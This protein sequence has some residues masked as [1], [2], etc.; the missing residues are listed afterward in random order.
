VIGT[1]WADVNWSDLTEW[2]LTEVSDDPAYAEVVTPLLLEILR[3][4]PDRAY[5]DVGCG[6]GRVM[7]AV[8]E[9]GATVHGVDINLDLARRAR[10]AMVG[11]ALEIPV[12]DVSY[13]GAYSVLTL[14]H[15]PNHD[16][17]FAETA[18]IIKPGGVLV[19]VVN[20]PQ[21]TAP[22]STPISDSDGEILWR[23]GDYFSSGSSDIPA[24][25][26]T[27]T[28]QH[29]SMGALLISAADVGWSLERMIEQPHH[30]YQDQIGILRLLACRWR[31]IG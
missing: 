29:R 12:R 8:A 16:R 22:G 11:D 13:D 25:E 14:E 17:F 2:W 6:E 19:I 3:P 27:V 26:G 15:I 10:L 20:H 23:P 30:E 9:W 21:W 31:L 1:Y 5:L 18:R 28:F 4:E 7:R 24:G